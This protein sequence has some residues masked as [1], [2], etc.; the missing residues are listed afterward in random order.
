MP[1][2]VRVKKD[3][4]SSSRRWARGPRSQV[5]VEEVEPDRSGERARSEARSARAVVARDD[6]E[7]PPERSV[8]EGLQRG[9]KPPRSEQRA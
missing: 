5:G 6:H 2:P 3:S 4:R 9:R 1:S 8:P 7:A